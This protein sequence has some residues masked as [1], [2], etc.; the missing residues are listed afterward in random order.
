MSNRRVALVW[1]PRVLGILVALF[2]GVFALDAFDGGHGFWG[3]F[4]GFLLHLIPTYL[5][6]ATVAL[7]WRRAWVGAV[8]F[9]GLAVSYAIVASGHPSWIAVIGGPLALVGALYMA[10]WRVARG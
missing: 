1:A 4:G 5:L 9:L 2:I 8:V 3:S 10:S 6:L 7:A